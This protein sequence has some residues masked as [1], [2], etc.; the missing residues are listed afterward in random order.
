MPRFPI[1]FALLAL[2]TASLPAA[3]A[4]PPANPQFLL[5]VGSAVGPGW[6]ATEIRSFGAQRAADAGGLASAALAVGAD[7]DGVPFISF[8]AAAG[9]RVD[10]RARGTLRYG[11]S[12]AGTSTSADLVPVTITTLGH[13]SGSITAQALK[14]DRRVEVSANWLS[15]LT[16]STFDT[17]VAD[18]RRNMRTEGVGTGGF[19]Q[20]VPTTVRAVDPERSAPGGSVSASLSGSFFQTFTLLVK[21]NELNTVVMEVD[22]GLGGLFGYLPS[23]FHYEPDSARYNWQLSG[24]IDPVI[25]IDAAYASRFSVVQSDIPMVLVPE[26]SSWVML[27]AGLGAMAFVSRRRRTAA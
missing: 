13:F 16:K 22:G 18:G 10:A 5:E 11:W 6:Q 3:A 23:A 2:S 25:T 26:V 4:V 27:L 19:Y 24:Y 12:I 20:S 8:S 15:M 1:C 14:T 7:A 17:A 21:P 9:S